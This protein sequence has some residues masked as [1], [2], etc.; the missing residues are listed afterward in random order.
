MQ[1]ISFITIALGLASAT[2]AA[3]GSSLYCVNQRYFR[4]DNILSPRLGL[5]L[6]V[7]APRLRRP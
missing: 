7:T 6:G 1:T 2:V 3:V 5:L 4:T